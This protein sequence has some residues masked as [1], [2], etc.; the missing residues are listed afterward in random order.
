MPHDV[1]PLWFTKGMDALPLRR[2]R[3]PIPLDWASER[4]WLRGDGSDPR[5]KETERSSMDRF[6]SFPTEVCEME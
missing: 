2:L 4:R 1:G 3:S 6:N 5:L